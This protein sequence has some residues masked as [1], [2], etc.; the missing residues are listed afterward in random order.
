[1]EKQVSIKVYFD[2]E[3]FEFYTN[4]KKGRKGQ[5]VRDALVLYK[6]L[7]KYSKSGGIAE[8][9]AEIQQGFARIED[10]LK[11]HPN[12]NSILQQNRQQEDKTPYKKANADTP[13]MADMF[14]GFVRMSDE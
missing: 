2:E 4:I 12:I 13:D 9:L 3:L 1:M 10:L 11:G 5:V 7:Q 8:I 6:E 14:E